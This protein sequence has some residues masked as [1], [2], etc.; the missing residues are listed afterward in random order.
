[1]SSCGHK[2][3]YWS[4][5]A[6]LTTVFLS[7]TL[8]FSEDIP[9]AAVS[10][11]AYSAGYTDGDVILTWTAPGEDGTVGTV[12]SYVVKYATYP[13]ISSKF[14]TASHGTL[15]P[16]AWT[17]LVSAGMTEVRVLTGLV[18]GTY[19]YYAIKARDVAQQRSAWTSKTDDSSINPNA[20]GLAADYQPSA[21]TGIAV[22]AVSTWT[23]SLAWTPSVPPV[24]YN[25][26][27]Y[28]DIYSGTYSF[29]QITNYLDRVGTVLYPG[30]THYIT[31]ITVNKLL[32]YSVV[33]RD[34]GITN[35]YYNKEL[36]SPVTKVISTS[37][38]DGI[39]PERAA[40]ITTGILS[41]A[42]ALS[43]TMPGDDGD[44]GNLVN[45]KVRIRWS[46]TAKITTELIWE[47]IP[48]NTVG[49]SRVEFSTNVIAGQRV[50][51]NL[52]GLV[53][54]TTYYIVVRIVDDGGNQ[55]SLPGYLTARPLGEGKVLITQVA[56]A[57]PDS[58]FNEY[59][60][61]YNTTDND[62]NLENW[63][64]QFMYPGYVS[65]DTLVEFS[66]N[67][68]ITP[69]KFYLI[70]SS[71]YNTTAVVH[72]DV[73]YN[74]IS[75]VDSG[76]HLRVVDGGQQEQDRVAWGNA[77][78][79]E[80]GVTAG[81]PYGP[82]VLER[83]PG[84][85]YE[86]QPYD[87]NINSADF[88]LRNSRNPHNDASPSEPDAGAPA[89]VTDFIAQPGDNDGEVRLTWTAP[90]DDLWVRKLDPGRYDIRYAALQTTSWKSADR[91]IYVS[92]VTQNMVP[93][94]YVITG[95]VKNSTYYFWLRTADDNLKW[96]TETV[97]T[98][99]LARDVEP[100][101]VS[102]LTAEALIY[103]VAL[104]WND[105]TV[106]TDFVNYNIFRST[107]NSESGYALLAEVNY[108]SYTDSNISTPVEY[109]YKVKSKDFNNYLSTYSV[110]VSAKPYVIKPSLPIP[111]EGIVSG[112]NNGLTRISW[113]GVRYN[114]NSSDCVDLRGYRVYG[115]ESMLSL[116]NAKK[117]IVE[118][119]SYTTTWTDPLF[120]RPYFYAL[121]AVNS[122]GFESNNSV[123]IDS[124]ANDNKYDILK[125]D[126]MRLRA[127]CSIEQSGDYRPSLVTDP[128][129][130]AEDL[131]GCVLTYLKNNEKTD[132]PTGKTAKLVF[133]YTDT[134]GVID[135]LVLNENDTAGKFGV[136][137]HNSVNWQWLG[138]IVDTLNNNVTVD[139]KNSGRYKL[140][141]RSSAGTG[142]GD[143]FKMYEIVP[144]RTFVPGGRVDKITFYIS[145]VGDIVPIGK[146]YNLDNVN[147]AKLEYN[148]ATTALT[149]DGRNE[150]GVYV[151]SGVYVYYISG[152]GKTLTGTIVVAR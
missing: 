47:T 77:H 22:T 93:Q 94:V 11:L 142:T 145:G 139:A 89:M 108:S 48:V 95:L 41:E 44:T 56:V 13:V 112:I 120:R 24:Y 96:S 43:W 124:L 125:D 148:A 65:W 17:G 68:V 118:V 21:V 71:T 122:Y 106:D 16:Q 67:A 129:A 61:I 30:T 99:G 107:Y 54:G 14:E 45:A 74:S 138:G 109:F 92:T 130:A 136:F 37:T 59:V 79:P 6:L 10:N 73:V 42:I 29:T 8:V 111:P 38:L 82:Q 28:Y 36:I 76:G 40:N 75:I 18:P 117:F 123:I 9:P 91:I 97:K 132:L 146:M 116:I 26:I 86:I 81:I 57:D 141:Q 55:S 114:D 144:S 98:P 140:S 70:A 53:N 128:V 60:E 152:K 58:S 78:S 32:Y 23:I 149:W 143:E 113:E 119:A 69:N 7:S 52:T 50:N 104:D 84:S 2:S 20:E 5:L 85:P 90:G 51:Y 80:G 19:Y 147:V 12:A 25:D 101:A 100:V 33:A 34:Y 115:G 131:Y 72:A 3:R 121:R 135:G 4:V 63:K 102:S 103:S 110:T 87:T 49:G 39:P 133:T 35:D 151:P 31:G 27:K 64:L 46:K 137:F 150:Y 126:E 134:N 88:K 83:L 105:N 66:S 62:I 1:M 15:Y 127:Y